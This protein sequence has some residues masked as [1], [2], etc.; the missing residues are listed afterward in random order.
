MWCVNRRNACR[1]IVL[2]ANAARRPPE[3]AAA[4]KA[5]AKHDKNAAG[6]LVFAEAARLRC[7]HQIVD[8]RDPCNVLASYANREIHPAGLAGCG[9]GGVPRVCAADTELFG[10]ILRSTQ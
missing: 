8:E 10:S 3:K 6:E 2:K 5:T 4:T 9:R 7:G 1:R